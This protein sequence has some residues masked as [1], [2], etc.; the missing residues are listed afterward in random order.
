MWH[1]F[2]HFVFPTL[3]N[4]LTLEHAQFL[5]LPLNPF[6]SLWKYCFKRS[7]CRGGISN[8][9]W[10]L[11]F[12]FFHHANPIWGIISSGIRMTVLEMSLR[13]EYEIVQLLFTNNLVESKI[14]TPSTSQ[15]ADR[16]LEMS[17]KPSA[18]C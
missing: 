8:S 15:W 11:A 17:A 13:K 9:L 14:S 5:Y 6:M 3:L 18:S 10:G 12:D 2:L 16:P 7:P 1:Y 4:R